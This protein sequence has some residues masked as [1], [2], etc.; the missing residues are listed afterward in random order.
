M[1]KMKQ[2]IIVSEDTKRFLVELVELIAKR[3][4]SVI[5]HTIFYKG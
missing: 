4:T 1:F 5:K 2:T 3:L